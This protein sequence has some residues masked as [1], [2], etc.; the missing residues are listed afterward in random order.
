MAITALVTA[1]QAVDDQAPVLHEVPV[2][3]PKLLEVL[4]IPVPG[5]AV[6]QGGVK[7]GLARECHSNVSSWLH[8]RLC[9]LSGIFDLQVHHNE[10]AGSAAWQ[11]VSSVDGLEV[12]DAQS[13]IGAGEVA[14]IL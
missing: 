6:L 7:G 14:F 3:V 1:V 5:D 10:P 11:K 2:T 13:P 12:L 8:S 4:T 9:D